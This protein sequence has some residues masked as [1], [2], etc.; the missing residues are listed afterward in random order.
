MEKKEKKLLY[1]PVKGDE[2]DQAMADALND[3]DLE[4]LE[5]TRMKKGSYMFGTK[6]IKT[7]IVNN[8][9]IVRVGGGYMAIKRFIETHAEEEIGK[10]MRKYE[11][12]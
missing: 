9:L 11:E 1:T 6:K 2:L 7:K 5:V 10:L 12:E 4:G 3:Q 8:N